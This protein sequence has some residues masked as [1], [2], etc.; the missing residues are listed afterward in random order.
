MLLTANL[1]LFPELQAPR[2]VYEIFI[3][4]SNVINNVGKSAEYAENHCKGF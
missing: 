2:K 3:Y 4:L 1:Q